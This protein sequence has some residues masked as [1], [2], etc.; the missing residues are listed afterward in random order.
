M[1]VGRVGALLVASMALL[2]CP[3]RSDPPTGATSAAPSAA[4]GPVASGVPMDP[5]AVSAAVN[6]DGKPAY[7]GPV[8]VVEGRIV[9]TGDP[10]FELPEVAAQITDACKSARPFYATLFREGEGRALADVLVGVTGYHEYVPAREPTQRFVAKDCSFGTRTIAL[11]LGQRIEIVSGDREAYIPELIGERGQ[12]QIIAT[13]GGHVA[14]PLYPTKAGRFMLIDN[15]KLFMTAEV[16]V[17]KY[18]TVSVTGI[19]GRYRISGLPPGELMVSA[20]L[21]PT[22]GVAHKK[23]QVE[24][25]KTLTVDLEI[26]FDANAFRQARAVAS[27]AKTPGPAPSGAASGAKKPKPAPSASVRR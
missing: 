1:I 23:I 12:A 4:P 15:L 2:G 5:K 16:L 21:P 6:P 7:S 17:L 20:V 9:A 25:G 3:R 11:T 14:S 22:G 10:S 26:A 18:A 19:D 13:P 27:G 8:G 24:G